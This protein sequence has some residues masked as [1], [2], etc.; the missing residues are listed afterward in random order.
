MVAG[1]SVMTN[2]PSRTLLN[3]LSGYTN[4]CLQARMIFCASVLRAEMH[5]SVQGFCALKSDAEGHAL[6]SVL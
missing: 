4:A 5:E 1:Q 6:M 2:P 3:R